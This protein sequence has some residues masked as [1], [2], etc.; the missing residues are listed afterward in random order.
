MKIEIVKTEINK[1]IA[2]VPANEEIAKMN[3]ERLIGLMDING[4]C[5]EIA[6]ELYEIDVDCQWCC[7]CCGCD[8]LSQTVEDAILIFSDMKIENTVCDYCKSELESHFIFQPSLLSHL[9]DI[10][11]YDYDEAIE[12]INDNMEYLYTYVIE[13][14]GLAIRQGYLRELKK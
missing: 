11:G 9:T 10:D 7:L 4:N 8:K 5:I 3:V 1:I 13:D 12:I 6:E 14:N 2:S